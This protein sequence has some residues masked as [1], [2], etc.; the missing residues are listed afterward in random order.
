MTEVLDLD[1][2][3]RPLADRALS[4]GAKSVLLKCG[5]PGLYLKTSGRMQETGRRIGL[6]A[7]AW[8][9]VG[10]FEKSFKVTQIRSGTGCGDTSIAAFLASILEGFGPADAVRMAAAAGALCLTQYDAVSGL[11][12]LDEIKRIVDNGWEKYDE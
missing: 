11:E 12:P 8:N 3:I 7:D 1:R 2:D 4:F 5:R 9:S 6:D 10:I